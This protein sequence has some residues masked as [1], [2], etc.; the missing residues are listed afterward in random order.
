MNCDLTE[1]FTTT[2][3]YLSYFCS[4]NYITAAE[5]QVRIR[6]TRTTGNKKLVLIN[7]FCC[8]TESM[9]VFVGMWKT[10]E[11]ETANKQKAVDE[12]K[13]GRHG[14]LEC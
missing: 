11:I 5:Q 2:V 7:D 4:E 3:Y 6:K 1:P 8:W 10:T 9:F 12:A 14:R 13:S